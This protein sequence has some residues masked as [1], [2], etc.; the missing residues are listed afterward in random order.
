MW[1]KIE[2]LGVV[3]GGAVSCIAKNLLNEIWVNIII[4]LCYQICLVWLYIFISKIV[5]LFETIYCLKFLL[6][7]CNSATNSYCWQDMC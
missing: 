7:S 5:R 3:V 6:L 2:D 4:S 1:K